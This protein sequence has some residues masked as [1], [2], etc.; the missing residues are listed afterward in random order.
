MFALLT[1]LQNNPPCALWRTRRCMK[2]MFL[3]DIRGRRSGSVSVWGLVCFDP[4][5][6]S[7]N[8]PDLS[9]YDLFSEQKTA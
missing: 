4:D 8:D 6:D 7:D 1:D 2:T 9:R 5:T 3:A